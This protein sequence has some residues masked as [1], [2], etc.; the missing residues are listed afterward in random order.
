MNMLYSHQESCGRC[1]QPICSCSDLDQLVAIIASA[2][3]HFDAFVR[4]TALLP[5]GVRSM[6]VGEFEKDIQEGIRD[7]K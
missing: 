2:A 6:T 5:N 3:P 4:Y 1:H 7:G